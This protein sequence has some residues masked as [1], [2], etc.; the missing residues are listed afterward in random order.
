M[1][2]SDPVT[3]N[4]NPSNSVS[5]SEVMHSTVQQAETNVVALDNGSDAS[6]SERGGAPV[7]SGN[8]FVAAKMPFF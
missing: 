2:A 6:E 5:S 4:G 1:K 8:E 3:D 7:V